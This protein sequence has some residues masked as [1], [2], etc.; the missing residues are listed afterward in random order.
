VNFA[1]PGS[2]ALAPATETL[3]DRRM[4][5]ARSSDNRRRANALGALLALACC[6][7]CAGA[8]AADPPVGVRGPIAGPTS[9]ASPVSPADAA[10][11]RRLISRLQAE[12]AQTPARSI[13]RFDWQGRTL[14]YVPA[15]CCDQYNEIYDAQGQRLCAPDGGFTGRGDQRC[16]E[17]VVDRERLQPVWTDPRR[18]PA[19]R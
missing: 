13:L 12:P 7:A 4:L 9:P 14:Y 19:P 17:I 8:P 18:L 10:G 16:P 11:L 5:D 15:P 2:A 3:Q 6:A 1:H